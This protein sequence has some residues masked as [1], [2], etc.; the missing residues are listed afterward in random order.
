MAN[1][2]ASHAAEPATPSR[3]EQLQSELRS[4]PNDPITLN[5]LAAEYV[6]MNRLAE[7]LEIMLRSISIDDK[8]AAT[9]TNL[10]GLYDRLGQHD[11]ALAEATAAARLDPG[12]TRVRAYICELDIVVGRASEAADCYRGMLNL[13]EP[14]PDI[15][16]KFA[17]ALVRSRQFDEAERVL[18]KLRARDPDDPVVLNVLGN[19][20]YHLKEYDTSAALLKRAVERSPD[21]AQF[22]YNLA[23]AYLASENR[24]GALSQYKLIK[25]TDADLAGKLY[26]RLF[27]KYLL[28]ARSITEKRP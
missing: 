28:D 9:R 21:D 22:R 12:N 15:E 16:I 17:I 7:A 4:S 3:L 24:A 6:S 20:H 1:S 27:G 25:E 14:P 13:P 23:M 18:E 26:R 8:I 11:K 19:F 10:A 2:A 5:N